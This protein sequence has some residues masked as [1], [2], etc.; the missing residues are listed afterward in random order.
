MTD[1]DGD[2]MAVHL[3]LSVEAQAEAHVLMLSPHNIFSPANGNP[4]IS[5]SQDILL[6]AYY[7]T[8]VR[9]DAVLDPAKAPKF[10]DPHEAILA[11][12]QK[13]VAI[14]TPIEVRL[15]DGRWGNLVA[16]QG[17]QPETLPANRRVLTTV[18]RLLFN[19][20]LP[21]GMTFYPRPSS[22]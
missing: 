13:K 18:G 20:I 9:G 7:L 4:I 8:M 6:G 11:Y 14:H 1:F 22:A 10:R 12:D 2:Q 17:K 19:E 15:P 16:D 21:Q 5:P 3:P